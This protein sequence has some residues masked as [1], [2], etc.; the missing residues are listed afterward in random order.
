M[1]WLLPQP[2][3]SLS[4]V[5]KLDGQHTGKLRKRDNLLKGEGEEVKGRSQIKRRKETLVL[6]KSFNTLC[7]S[8]TSCKALQLPL[9]SPLL[10]GPDLEKYEGKQPMHICHV[11]LW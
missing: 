3:P 1:I 4:S 8:V 5:S 10:S 6:Y 2:L 9:S 11:L 7:S